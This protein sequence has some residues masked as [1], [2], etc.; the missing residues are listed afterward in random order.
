MRTLLVSALA[1]GL[2]A[3]ASLA[4]E[5]TPG[6]MD[7]TT[8]GGTVTIGNITQSNTQTQPRCRFNCNRKNSRAKVIAAVP[9]KKVTTVVAS[10]KNVAVVAA[11]GKNASASAH[12]KTG[13]N[14]NSQR[15]ASVIVKGGKN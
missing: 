5:L 9:G 12:A 1:L 4:A 10:G 2:T 6:E 3:S 14:T 11:A 8:A 13:R 7:G 15:V